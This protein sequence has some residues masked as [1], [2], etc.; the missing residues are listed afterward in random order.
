VAI[1]TIVRRGPWQAA[2]KATGVMCP[3][4]KRR[5]ATLTAE[6]DTFF[7]IPASVKVRG[8]RVT[9]CV[10]HRGYDTDD[11]LDLGFWVDMTR[12]NAGAFGGVYTPPPVEG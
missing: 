1:S 8:V 7:S 4:G 5:V 2:V 11:D 6:P 12:K 3:D 9:G 10:M